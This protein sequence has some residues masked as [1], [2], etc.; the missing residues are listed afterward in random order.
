VLPLSTPTEVPF[1]RHELGRIL[2]DIG[3][4]YLALRL[5]T[6]DPAHSGP[7]HTPRLSIEQMIEVVD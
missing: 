7:P 2:G 5:G 1:T 3:F 4:P 6:L